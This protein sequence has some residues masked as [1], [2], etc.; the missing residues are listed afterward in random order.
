MAD[1]KAELER[2]KARLEAIRKDRQR[3]EEEKRQKEES[4]KNAVKVAEP[5]IPIEERLSAADRLLQDLGIDGSA[6]SQTTS[7][8]KDVSS[9][10]P[11]PTSNTSCDVAN[12]LSKRKDITLSI[13]HQVTQTS[14]PPKEVVSYDKETQT[15]TELADKEGIAGYLSNVHAYRQQI[16]VTDHISNYGGSHRDFDSSRGGSPAFSFGSPRL[17]SHLEWDDEFRAALTYGMKPADDDADSLEVVL[18][19]TLH[20]KMPHVEMVKAAHTDEDDETP[21]PAPVKELSEEEKQQI[22]MTEEY[23][24]FLDRS[25]RVVERALTQDTDIFVD[26][27]GEISDEGDHLGEKLKQQRVF[28]DE[29]WTKHRL[30]TCLDWSKQ[31]QELLL[32][33]YSTNPELPHEPEGVCLVWNS[34]FKKESPEYIFHCQSAVTTCCF[35]AFHPN[36]YVGGTYSGQVVVWDNRSNKRMPVQRTPLSASAHTHPIYCTSVVGTENAH[37]LITVSTDG[38]VCSWSLDML[39]Q[40]QDSMNLIATNKNKLPVA[41]LSMSFLSGDVNNFVIGGEDGAVNL[42]CRHG[43][44][45]GV[46]LSLEEHNGP[47]TGID[48]HKVQGGVDFSH[49]Y[50]TSSF[51]W[52]VKLWST[53]GEHSL[54]TFKDGTEYV[55]DVNW[56]PIHPAL[57]ASVDGTGKLSLWNLNR[58]TEVPTASTVPDYQSALNRCKWHSSG[59]H[60]AVGSTTGKIY[61]YDVVERLATPRM[62][63]WNKFAHTL[64]EMQSEYTDMNMSGSSPLR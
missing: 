30:V 22:M 41:A 17:F 2:K 9:E 15:A 1:R 32:A 59:T 35:A 20:S 11:M 31:Y 24:R 33:S 4:L 8:T 42:A 63:E 38:K 53:R 21:L 49:L 55:M 27:T 44:K 43:S 47:V 50:L 7:T 28:Y 61:L 57:F 62:D 60:L 46:T 19:N 39:S 16:S 51:D 36:L 56:S 26:Y 52:T 18:D 45:A 3:K 13:A 14:I 54:Y 29:H 37:N 10:R 58:D 5:D 23:K 25:S 6:S 12:I 34:M 40:P 64:L 48:T